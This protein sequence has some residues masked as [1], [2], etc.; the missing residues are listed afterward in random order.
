MS[1]LCSA[2]IPYPIPGNPHP[3][4]APPAVRY[5]CEPVIPGGWHYSRGAARPGSHIWFVAR[6]Y[7][8]RSPRVS[9]RCAVSVACSLSVSGEF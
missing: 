1:D 8:A 6:G 3:C 7:D 2:Q 4:W 9:V 5:P